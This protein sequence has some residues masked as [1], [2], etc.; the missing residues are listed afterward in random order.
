[1]KIILDLHGCII[2]KFPKKEYMD[3]VSKFM[4]TKFFNEIKSYFHLTGAA[5]FEMVGLKEEYIKI[6]DKLP[7]IEYKDNQMVKILENLS[8]KH[9]LIL[10]SDSTMNNII[11]TLLA[12]G[13]DPSIFSK[14]IAIDSYPSKPS[15]P[16]TFMYKKAGKGFVVGDRITDLIPAQ[17]LKYP[18]FL[19]NYSQVKRFLR[20]L[21]ENT[22]A[23]ETIV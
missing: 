12:A 7:V 2:K 22:E 4:D 19:G 18:G 17:K 6:L 1:M 16:G 5:V 21:N 3:A 23:G 9:E 20:W 15:K 14:I 10:I 13:I 8:Q 11:K